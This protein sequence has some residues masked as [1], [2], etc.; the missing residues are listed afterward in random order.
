MLHMCIILLPYLDQSLAG[1]L[2][3]GRVPNEMS[4][5]RQRAPETK[6]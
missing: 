1:P 4:A 5:L 2:V 6:Q 3:M